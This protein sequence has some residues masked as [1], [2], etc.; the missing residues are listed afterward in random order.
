MSAF[1]LTFDGLTSCT[2]KAL[3]IDDES[4]NRF[5]LR[6]LL[7][8]F[9]E[10]VEIMGEAESA[11]EGFELIKSVKP[12]V[13]FLD[14][15]MPHE[16]G[17][18]LLRKFQEIDFE[19]IFVTSFDKYAIDAI[20]FNALD[21]LLKPVEVKELQSAIERARKRIA[22]K[23]ENSAQV[24]NL[25]SSLDEPTPQKI[26]VH[27]KDSVKLVNLSEI[28]SITGDGSYSIIRTVGNGTYTVSKY[29][30]DFESY[31]GEDSSFLRVSRSQIINLSH[32]K[33]YSKGEPCIIEMND[34]TTV[35]VSRR[36]KTEVLQ[37]LMRI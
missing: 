34:G 13:V 2:M 27:D 25:L 36:K 18:E 15:Q 10:D 22:T 9:F 4:N 19:I 16:N 17:F 8:R 11:A 24:S 3:L 29:L 31:F 7:E 21:Y 1:G 23:Q 33:Q 28:S 26:A 37:L 14:I 30:K 6:S 5:V 12:D 32:I 35:E 20:R